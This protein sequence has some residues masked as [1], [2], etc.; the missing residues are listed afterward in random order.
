VTRKAAA[1][2]HVS[3][4]IHDRFKKN[5]QDHKREMS[6]VVEELMSRWLAEHS[7]DPRSERVQMD[8]VVRILADAVCT[9]LGQNEEW[10]VEA[11]I[12]AGLGLP[13]STVFDRR[14]GHFSLEKQE[15]GSKF[16]RWLLYRIIHFLNKGQKVYLI[17]DSG[18]TIFWFMKAFGE[19]VSDYFLAEGQSKAP[20][21]T[22]VGP[23]QLKNITII[24]NNIPGAEAFVTYASHHTIPVESAQSQ[25]RMSDLIECRLL[26]G[27]LLPAYVAVT[28]EDTDQDLDDLCKDERKRH[29]SSVFI[30]VV[31]GNWVSIGGRSKPSGRL[32]EDQLPY[33]LARGRGHASFKTKVLEA[34]DEIFAVAPF[35]QSLCGACGTSQ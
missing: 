25:I 14:I 4:A 30:G 18:T 8:H 10:A 31:T 19:I 13:G 21:D 9:Q 22:R 34:A 27:T 5:A 7:S 17:C 11:V 2:F 15:L 28:G 32:R 29:A 6:E 1:T 16:S 12:H 33:L 20:V 3:K 26:A 24:T 35:G 23:E